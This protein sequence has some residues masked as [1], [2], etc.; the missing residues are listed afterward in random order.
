M[1]TTHK[2]PEQEPEGH[3][4]GLVRAVCG[5]LA[6]FL[7]FYGVRGIYRDDVFIPGRSGPG[8][9]FHGLPAWMLAGGLFCFAAF[10][11]SCLI[12]SFEN[13]PNRPVYRIFNRWMKY[14]GLGLF[15]GAF[16]VDLLS[17]HKK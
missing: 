12:R 2:E 8:V 17:I 15:F 3:F 11:I 1:S 13:P 5:L 9:D 14:I 7:L 4:Q 6:A 16:V 10:L